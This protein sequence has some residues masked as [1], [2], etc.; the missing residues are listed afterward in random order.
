MTLPNAKL[1]LVRPLVPEARD[2]GDPYA[3]DVPASAGAR[4][5]YYAYTT[6]GATPEGTAFP[7]YGSDDLV[8]WQPLGDSLRVGGDGAHWAPCVR[9]IPACERPY[10]MLYSRAIGQGQQGHV[11]HTIYRADSERPEGPFLDSGHVLTADLEFAIDPD[12]YTLPDGSLNLAFAIDFTGN[13]PLGTGIVEATINDDL[14]ALTGPLR[15]LARAS[16][17]WQVYD[18]ARTLPWMTIPGVDWARDTVRWHT[19]EGPAGGLVNPG[20]ARVYLYSG[21]CFFG[22]Y[23]V[24]AL[25][26]RPDG[27][28][29]DVSDG[30]H[31]VVGPDPARGFHGPG[32]CSLLHDPD[33]QPHLLLHAR[34]GAA[35]APRQMCL[36]PLDWDD[37]GRPV[38]T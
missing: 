32:H 7:V 2:Q 22:F 11:G 24:G 4:F 10:V 36:V 33:G 6:G 12:I 25:I 14:T 3:L 29:H 37:E 20:G 9:Y 35:D 1:P 17:D 31:L 30:H 26:E 19:L 23:A 38:V 21:G 16:H 28:L 18:P 27:S 13:E 5:R 34:F 8:T 15:T